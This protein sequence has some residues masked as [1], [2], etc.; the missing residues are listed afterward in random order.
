MSQSSFIPSSDPAYKT[1][2][3]NFAAKCELYETEI[4]LSAQQ[5]LQ[6]QSQA[7]EFSASYDTVEAMK[8]ELKGEIAGKDESRRTSTSNA[9]TLAK[10]IK[11]T[12]GVTPQILGALGIVSSSTNGPVVPVTDLTV[13][14]CSDGVNM[15]KWKRNGNAQG[16]MFLIESRLEGSS[17]WNLVS[18]VSKTSFNDIDQIPGQTQYY[19]IKSVRAG[20]TSSP[21]DPA[22]VYSNGFDNTLT[23]AA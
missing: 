20:V 8:L 5:I 19:R 21:C 1:W 16:T 6:I 4:G 2:L 22:V 14:G 23:L 9:R 18:A 11:G 3:S 10:Q 15:L 7:A 12:P 13:Q 17:S